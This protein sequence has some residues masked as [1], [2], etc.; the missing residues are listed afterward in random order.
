[1]ID[2]NRLDL[3]EMIADELV[4]IV[5]TSYNHAEYLD[6]RIESI[7]NQT[8]KNIEIIVVDDCSIDDS[9]EVLSKYEE[10]H[11]LTIH[12]LKKNHGHAVAC[13][14]G[15]GLCHGE[16]IMFAECDD[17][18]E[19]KHV[20]VLM[21]A[22]KTYRSA[23]V[24]FCRSNMVNGFGKKLGDDFKYR[25]KNFQKRCIRDTLIFSEEMQRFLLIHCVIPNMSAALIRKKI[26]EEIGG[27]DPSF[28][29]CADWDFWC[30]TAKRCDC[31][32]ST[33][34]LNNFRTHNT[35][36]R[37]TSGVEV[38]MLEILRLLKSAAANLKMSP[39][40]V[41]R[42]KVNICII[43]ANY[44]VSNP[45]AWIKCFHKI[46]KECSS[47]SKVVFAYFFAGLI[48]RFKIS[49]FNRFQ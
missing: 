19:P 24:A 37:N 26:F 23:G 15:V 14:I 1:M 49:V 25:E 7:L 20:E 28:R 12:A 21:N 6:Q 22:L 9:L 32:Y 45:V 17:F 34:A 47:F 30:R 27:L 13:N 16:F 43:W 5:V 40:E 8:Y 42:F 4:S 46:Y 48:M 39:S 29:A 36:V 18:N 35:T 33:M 11:N 41:F 31:Y 3:N 38:P 2:L 44:L 10:Y